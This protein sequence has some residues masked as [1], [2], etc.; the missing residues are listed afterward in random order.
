[1][2]WSFSL[3]YCFGVMSGET[4][5]AAM[6][7]HVKLAYG[8]AYTMT[9]RW[10]ASQTWEGIR[11]RFS[12]ETHLSLKRQL[13]NTQSSP[14]RLVLAKTT[15][16]TKK[17]TAKKLTLGGMRESRAWY[18]H[19]FEVSFKFWKALLTEYTQLRFETY[20]LFF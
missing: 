1:L 14:S 4:N 15:V 19:F 5:L 7:L 18:L 6:Q 12:A 10:P 20:F 16:F 2:L 11:K 13:P 17:N 8:I 9:T 3:I